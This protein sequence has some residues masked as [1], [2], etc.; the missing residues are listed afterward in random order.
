MSATGLRVY[1]RE[2]GLIGD[3]R[4]KHLNTHKT[5]RIRRGGRLTRQL[6]TEPAE[7]GQ[8]GQSQASASCCAQS[9]VSWPFPSCQCHTRVRLVSSQQV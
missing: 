2:N 5:V 7:S 1:E 8:Q 3:K 6:G 4:K 9:T